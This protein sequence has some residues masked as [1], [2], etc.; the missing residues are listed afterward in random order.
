MRT[1]GGGAFVLLAP[2]QSLTAAPYSIFALS[3]GSAATASNVTSGAV[4]SSVNTLKDNVVLQAGTNVTITPSGNTL[5]I[6]SAGAGGSGIWNLNGTNAYFTTGKV[7]IGTNAPN[8]RLRISGGPA[9]TANGWTGSLE[10]DNA[11]AIGWRPNA[12][13]QSY[14]I[15]PST[16]GLYFFQS[17]SSP[18]TT[19]AGASYLME[20]TD[21]GNLLVGLGSATMAANCRL[22]ALPFSPPPAAAAM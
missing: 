21:S 4:V 20:M 6:A 3:A 5:T 10:L 12:G 1:N 9:W 22:M 19:A 7:G 11:S 16:G 17:L 2:R 13:G 14:G 15:G 18:G 8:H